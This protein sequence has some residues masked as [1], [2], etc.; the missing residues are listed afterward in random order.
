[1]STSEDIFWLYERPTNYNKNMEYNCVNPFTI[2]NQN[3]P[4]SFKRKTYIR[5]G[6]VCPICIDPILKKSE[7]YLTCC[8]H[9]FHKL[10]IFKCFESKSM[11]KYASNFKCPVCRKNQGMD[12]DDINYRYDAMSGSLD[13]VENFNIRNKYMRAEQCPSNYNHYLGMN[14]NCSKC[15]KYRKTGR[16]EE[17][18]NIRTEEYKNIRT[19]K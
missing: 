14:Q 18:K 5:P 8:G 1:M 10:C 6:E 9:S 2:G 11:N 17:Q 4:C 19:E 15:I 16:T 13:E 12:M 3:I 7:A